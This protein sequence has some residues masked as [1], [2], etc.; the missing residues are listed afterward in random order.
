MIK[1]ESCN[2]LYPNTRILHKFQETF[3]YTKIRGT[4]TN[5]TYTKISI[6]F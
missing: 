4:K 1:F 2:T 5:K 3:N 6:F